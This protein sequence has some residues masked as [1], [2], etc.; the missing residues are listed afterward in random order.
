LKFK[1]IVFLMF[2]SIS[3]SSAQANDSNVVTQSISEGLQPKVVI[4]GQPP[5]LSSLKERM[6]HYK[7]PAVSIAF[8]KNHNISWTYTEGV[9]DFIDNRP[10]DE[11]TVFQAASISKPVFASVLMKYRQDNNLNLD[12][13]VNT[14]LK[15]WQLP[16]HQWTNK[17]DV[18][19]RRLLSHS[20]GATVHG[21]AGYSKGTDIPSITSLLNGVK[22]SNSDPIVIDIEPGTQFRYSGGGTTVAQL[23]LEDRTKSTLTNLAQATLFE[24]LMMQHSSF[25]Q[26]LKGTLKNN[27][28]VAHNAEG[29]PIAGGSNNYATLSAAGLWTT[30]SDLL[31]LVSQI[32]LASL[33]KNESFFSKA[34]VDEMLTPQLPP[35]GIGFFLEGEGKVTSFSHGGA[36]KG[37]MAHLFAHTKTGDGIVIMTNGDNGTALIDEIMNRISDI[38]H[39]DEFNPIEKTVTAL[40]PKL[41]K[42]ILGEY[43]ITEPFDTTLVIT[44]KEG[45][46]MVNI[47]EFVV[48]EMFFPESE[49]Q[50]FSMTGMSLFLHPNDSGEVNHISFWGGINATKK[51]HKEELLKD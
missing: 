45:K 37:F 17:S 24:P 47:G 39:W 3:L 16:E 25:S 51:K 21:F 30:P 38:Y 22:P 43:K 14:L 23:V 7:V 42:S 31:R 46:F 1:K 34:T 11:N 4:K 36:N 41:F 50:L 27:A 20:A 5:K 49:R 10:I 44:E 18:T 8:L 2:S 40:D 19:L 28:A 6:V 26:P 13:N 15:S 35:M 29:N 48:D 12:I 32:Q 33:G 9:I